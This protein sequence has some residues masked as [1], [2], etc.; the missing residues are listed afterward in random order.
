MVKSACTTIKKMNKCIHPCK[1][2]TM[3]TKNGKKQICKTKFDKNAVPKN[4]SKNKRKKRKKNASRTPKKTKVKR[5]NSANDAT[6]N[7]DATTAVNDD[8]SVNDDAAVNDAA[9]TAV[10]DAE[11]SQTTSTSSLQ[12]II[13]SVS[14]TAST[15]DPL[16]TFIKSKSVSP[17]SVAN[18]EEE[19]KENV[20]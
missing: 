5:K 18:N 20:Q 11:Q 12:K 9:T 7:D 10:N 2:I 15:F 4:C 1:K 19:S 6:V 17:I 3:N 14:S 8:V 16:K 13:N